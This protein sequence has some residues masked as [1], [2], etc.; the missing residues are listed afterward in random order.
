MYIRTLSSRVNVSVLLYEVGL[1]V[2]SAQRLLELYVS[3]L[4]WPFLSDGCKLP[5]PLTFISQLYCSDVF[6]FIHEL[7]LF[8]FVANK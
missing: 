7:F 2:F 4:S 1:S 5:F 6:C 8:S 3:F